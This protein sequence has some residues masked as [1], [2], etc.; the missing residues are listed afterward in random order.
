MCTCTRAPQEPTR[1]NQ[2]SWLC[3]CLMQCLSQ[4]LHEVQFVHVGLGL[5]TVQSPSPTLFPCTPRVQCKY[6]MCTA[7]NLESLPYILLL[8]CKPLLVNVAV[9][10]ESAWRTACRPMHEIVTS[11]ISIQ[12]QL[13][14]LSRC[15]YSP[16]PTLPTNKQYVLSAEKAA[17]NQPH[18][19]TRSTRGSVSLHVHVFAR[20]VP[21][22]I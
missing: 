4:V 5:C 14:P 8:L 2:S 3:T 7:H 19:P 13:A 17:S 9:S 21:D 6:S 20:L 1:E 16:L 10:K 18:P 11:M 15:P 22:R 12:R